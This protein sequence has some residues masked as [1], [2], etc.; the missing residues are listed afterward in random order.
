[1]VIAIT[2]VAIIQWK[3]DAIVEKVIGK[4]ENQ[5]EDPL[6]YKALHLEWFSY[7]PCIA[8]RI[9]GLKLGPDNEPLIE[10]GHVD[11]VLRLFPLFKEK[12]VINRLLISDSRVNIVKRNSHWSYEVFKKSNK[13]SEDEWNALVNQVNLEKTNL[14]YNDQEGI[15]LSI[16]IEDAKLGGVISGKM[17]DADIEMRGSIADLVTGSYKLPTA[18]SFNLSGNYKHDL[19]AGTQEYNNWKIKNMGMDLEGNGSTRKEKDQQFIEADIS[20][21]NG[22]AETLKQFIPNKNIKDWEGY[23]FSIGFIPDKFFSV[24]FHLT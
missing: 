20:W 10:G 16:D 15:S 6:R 18:F 12:I 17:L 5:L 13:Q 1:M 11:I 2:L 19:T 3:G 22:D 24:K 21:K 4:V 23:I 8:L 7:F 9:D 14:V